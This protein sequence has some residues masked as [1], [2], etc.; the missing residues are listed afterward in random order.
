MN[1]DDLGKLEYKCRVII[2]A[3]HAVCRWAYAW[4]RKHAVPTWYLHRQV[5]DCIISA[6]EHSAG[7][8]LAQVGPRS[9]S[10]TTLGYENH[11]FGRGYVPGAYSQRHRPYDYQMGPGQMYNGYD[12]HHQQQPY[13]NAS[14]MANQIPVGHYYQTGVPQAATQPQMSFAMGQAAPAPAPAPATVQASAPEAL[15][16]AESKDKKEG[17]VLEIAALALTLV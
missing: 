14:P 2:V 11:G 3:I 7:T 8:Q 10:L 13:A 6:D 12:P 5:N 9:G 16:K 15:P 4:W 1:D 17:M